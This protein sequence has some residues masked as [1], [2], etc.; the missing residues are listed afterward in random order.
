MCVTGTDGRLC[1]QHLPPLQT[2]PMPL[3]RYLLTVRFLIGATGSGLCDSHAV[4][5]FSPDITQPTDWVRARDPFQGISKKPFGF[6]TTITASAPPAG[7]GAPA[8]GSR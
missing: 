5:D 4:A 2:P 1:N 8:T 7:A 6:I 3:G